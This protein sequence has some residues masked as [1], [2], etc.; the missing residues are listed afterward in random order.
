MNGVR[1]H[2]GC[3]FHWN[4]AVKIL[5]LGLQKSY[6]EKGPVFKFCRELVA[7][8]FLPHEWIPH[9]FWQYQAKQVENFS[10][11]WDT[12]TIGGSRAQT[13]QTIAGVFSIV[14][15]GKTMMLSV[16]IIKSTIKPMVLPSTCMSSSIDC[17][18][19][20]KMWKWLAVWSKKDYFCRETNNANSTKGFMKLGTF[21]KIGERL[22]PK[23]FLKRVR[24]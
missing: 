1:F 12:W 10:S 17:T 13:S 6:M 16:T 24:N 15:S 19:K 4:Q 11:W 18:L 5:E 23:L 3:L 9:I 20:G 21:L 2:F 7:L 14:Y 8:P 22:V